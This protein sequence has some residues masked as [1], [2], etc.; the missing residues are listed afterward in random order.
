MTS[1]RDWLI[2]YNVRDVFPFLEALEKQVA[3]YRGLGVDMLKDSI[4]I[5]GVCMKYLFSTLPSDTFFSLIGEKQRDLHDTFRDQLVGGPSLVFT[6]LLEKGVTRLR[7]G[8]KRV[9][10]LVGYDANSLYLW[11][12]MQDMPTE[13]PVRRRQENG[14]RAEKIDPYGLGAREWLTWLSHTRG[15][16]IR[17]KFNGKERR[18]GENNIPVDGWDGKTVYQYHG[19][20]WHGHQCHLTE[21]LTVNPVS[22][23]PM[24]VLR[25]K[26]RQIT[27]YL[28]SHDVHLEA[29]WECEWLATKRRDPSLRAFL[30]EHC[31]PRRLAFSDGGGEVT[32]GAVER[33][34]RDNRLFGAVRCDIEVPDALRDKFSEFQPIFK[35]TRVGREDAGPFMR[36]YCEERKLVS[37]PRRTLIGSYF[38]KGILLATPLLKWYLEHGLVMTDV[39]EIVEYRPQACFRRFGDTVCEARRCGDADPSKT[40][41]ADTFKLLGNSA[42][43]KCITNL[44]KHREVHYVSGEEAG[45]FVNSPLFRTM[46]ELSD[47][48]EGLHE[49]ELGKKHL[50]WAL[51]LQIGFFVYQYAK[52]R[53]LQFHYD[54]LDRF[55]DRADYQLAQMDTDSLYL[56]LSTACL[57]DAVK[58]ELKRTF[59]REFSSWFP[60]Q[61]CDAHAEEFVF[62]RLQQVAPPTHPCCLARRQFDKRRPG[63]FKEEY[64]GSGIIALCSKTYFCFGEGGDKYSSKGLS[65]HT[66]RLTQDRFREVLTSR[67]SGGGVNRSFR[68]DGV[69]VYTYHQQRRSLSFVYLKR[70]V[71]EDGV[72]TL[73]CLL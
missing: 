36:A 22:G 6:R 9:Q 7:G 2:D 10:S 55:V 5:P 43:G 41:L 16:Y 18:V 20:L 39:Q 42:Y 61:A 49:V 70:R 44:T 50:R 30:A 38:G 72:N 8:E 58:P 71:C 67:V 69:S 1:L 15:I 27:A 25:E 66:N 73:P 24:E 51:P 46:R 64:N 3:F 54:M 28:L 52:L 56:A 47:R 37:Q 23:V 57:E 63:L 45:R 68:T 11:A 60:G 62:R 13:Y 26:T 53:M 48:G 17:H 31:P 32:L 4:S 19:C 12:L 29:I 65:Q 40:I 35:N 34:I 59:Y 14:F 33:A 21:G